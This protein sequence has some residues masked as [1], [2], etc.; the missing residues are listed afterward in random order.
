MKKIILL[1]IVLI[2]AAIPAVPFYIGTTVEKTFR[3]EH[4][5]GAREAALSG[6]DI[7][8]V[9]YQ[10]GLLSATAT[11]RISPIV[12]EGEETVAFE[13]RHR[14]DHIPQL[15][16]Q[17]IATVESELVPEDEAAQTVGTL[18]NDQSPF[19]V[20]TQIFLDGHQEATFS[21]PAA[22]GTAGNTERGDVVWQGM[23]GSIWQS[24][25]RDHI[26]FDMKSPGI[27]VKPERVDPPTTME[28][29][30]QST[31][32]NGEEFAAFVEQPATPMPESI[33][34]GELTY[35]GDMK[36]GASGMWQGS[37]KGK[38]ASFDIKTMD[39]N[40]NATAVRFDTLTLE[41]GQRE[42]N[43]LIKA[44]AL[45]T[46]KQINV[47]GLEL[48]N[49]VYDVTIEN[50]D[51]G[52]LLAWQENTQK[53]MRGEADADNPFAPMLAHLPA[54][55]NAQP[56]LTI[57]DLSVDSPMGRFAMKLDTRIQG[58][59][60]DTL[61]LNPLMLSTMITADLDASV[62]RTV[63]ISA[64]QQKMRDAMITQ[65][66]LNETELSDEELENAVMQNSDKQ[67]AG[68][69]AQGFIK[70]NAAQLES[71]ITFNAGKLT[72]NG[73]DASPLL[74]GLMQ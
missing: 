31:T 30:A 40:G 23:E 64:L 67:L 28:G 70:E 4:E 50:L 44:N 3:A 73:M 62:P 2:A 35:H 41:G 9:D 55:V 21:S 1:P 71:H 66:A 16:A 49:G 42:E 65:A 33:E 29:N 60:D 47:N 72:I 12:P 6:F 43:G 7:E 56:V 26:T 18:F 5:E 59:W 25:T 15:S 27:V 69:I 38:L 45:I 48:T 37:A 51:A 19:T 17:V 11:T 74:T 24:A 57:N 14:I 10:R 8:L 68:L 61:M 54:I 32:M 36:K 22:S 39:Q 53:M 13:L 34:L 20:H 58:K 63:V 46:L 52:A